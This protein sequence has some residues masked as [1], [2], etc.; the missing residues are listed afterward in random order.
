MKIYEMTQEQMNSRAKRVSNISETRPCYV[1]NDNKFL[2]KFC[3]R[4][5]EDL[6]FADV[7]EHEQE[8][9]AHVNVPLAKVRLTDAHDNF[10][11]GYLQRYHS[12]YKNLSVLLEDNSMTTSE[13][14][15]I[16]RKAGLE[17]RKIHALQSTYPDFHLGQIITKDGDFSLID[18]DCLKSKYTS[19][20]EFQKDVAKDNTYWLSATLS[21]LYRKDFYDGLEYAQEI[22]LRL[23]IS[24]EKADYLFEEVI[25][26]KGYNMDI[27]TVIDCFDAA[28]IE[29]DLIRFDKDQS[30]LDGLNDREEKK[31]G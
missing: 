15:T 10:N 7:L 18:I 22:L 4:A 27:D 17:L 1:S 11:C 20:E 9:L 28:R 14:L 31:R 13:R 23:N 21:F 30:I 26:K 24:K 29:S 25:F 2:F 16:M 8:K 12:M 3:S 6:S 5:E 19:E